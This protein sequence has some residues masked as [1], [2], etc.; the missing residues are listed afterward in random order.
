MAGFLF[1][2]IGSALALAGLTYGWLESSPG[3]GLIAT[4]WRNL[5]P[6]LGRTVAWAAL[7]VLLADLS[8][9]VRRNPGQPVVLLDASL[10]L[11][12][13]SG[14]WKEARDS[15]GRWGEI[16]LFGDERAT[17][18]T[19]PSRGRSQL[20]AALEAAAASARPVVVVSDGEIEDLSDIPS[21]L[22]AHTSVRL[23]PR[24]PGM[25]LAVTGVTA[26]SRVTAGDSVPLEISVRAF[27]DSAPAR[28][29]L[30]VRLGDRVLAEREVVP[31]RGG[32]VISRIGLASSGLRPEANLLSI[33]LEGIQDA[34][35]RD[36]ARQ[37]Q[38]TVTPTPGVVLLGDPADWDSRFLYR[39]LLDVAQLPVRGYLRMEPGRWRNYAD[40]SPVPT[41]QVRRAARGADLLIVK[42]DQAETRGSN[43]RGLL[44]WPSGD[45]S[46]LAGDWYLSATP[47]SPVA[48][49]FVAL[50]VD[51]FPPATQLSVM[52]PD[53]ADWIALT[54]QNGRRGA[55]RPVVSGGESR[56]RREMTISV[57]GLWRWAFR[58]GSSEQAYRSFV[59]SSVSWLL[60]GA[61]SATG[62]ARPVRPVV[63]NGRPVVFEWLGANHPAPLEIVWG[64]DGGGRRDT[65][66][67]DGAG[68]A[69][70][71]LPVGS[72]SYRLEG[73]GAG[74]VAVEEYSDEWLPRPVVLENR[75]AATLAARGSSRA[76]GWVWL[77]GLAIFGLG[78]EWL[79]RR[80]LGLR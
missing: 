38:V 48:G 32:E 34:E 55:E 3:S 41:E 11:A 22:L 19:T 44:H 53:S 7:G 64:G 68:K 31:V 5:V 8:C 75:E 77:F 30:Q 42:G 21:D 16:R 9:A 39:T 23:F 12:A 17:T 27:G 56:N 10:S 4:L 63:T 60:G 58:G 62:Q 71:W 26:P 65:L 24:R 57:D 50:P 6:F 45:A 13:D 72:Y 1:L 73:G 51:S 25:D 52:S 18:D 69:E 49:A 54:A 14:R 35:P 46:A 29:R 79:G 37:V 40:L 33:A 76:R 70:S 15:A 20:S 74:S 59:A 67:F 80:R 36:N 78:V 66:R 61:D 28:A 47:I 43:A 2:I